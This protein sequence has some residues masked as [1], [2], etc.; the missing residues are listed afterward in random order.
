MRI[1]LDYQDKSLL[2]CWGNGAGE[3]AYLKFALR[4]FKATFESP[5]DWHEHC[6][7]WINLGF[8]LFTIAFSFPW[9]GKVPKDDGQCSGP[10]YGFAFHNDMLW[11]YTGKSTGRKGA[12]ITFQMPWAW[13]FQEHVILTE[14]E[15]H[16]YR[17]VLRSGKV[18]ER[19]ATIKSETRRWTRPWLPRVMLRKTID[20]EFS[21]E[22]GERSGSWKGGTIGCGYDMLPD[23][24]PA[25]ALRRMEQERKF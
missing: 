14:P 21:D 12:W 17:Y 6:R 11:I 22:V 24:S 25:E 20:V 13:R 16:P 8:G 1:A 2:R 7:A 4:G 10:T 5:S 19:T 23:E 15:T 9:R 3:I 18:Q